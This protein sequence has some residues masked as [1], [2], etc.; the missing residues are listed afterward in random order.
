MPLDEQRA[1]ALRAFAA[2]YARSLTDPALPAVFLAAEQPLEALVGDIIEAGRAAGNTAPGLGVRH[3]ADLLVSGATSLGLDVLHER[4]SL[5]DVQA[6]LDYHVSRI[7]PADA[8]A[9]R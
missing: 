9:R 3:E 5:A 4:R 8:A 2:Y 1:S 6:V 7:F